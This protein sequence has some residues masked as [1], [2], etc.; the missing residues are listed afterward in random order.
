MDGDF[1]NTYIYICISM[2]NNVLVCIIIKVQ[3]LNLVSNKESI[4]ERSA[5][6]IV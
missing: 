3:K 1:A 6:L 4:L 2:V 5:Q